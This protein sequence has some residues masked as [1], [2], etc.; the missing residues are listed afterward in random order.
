M[1][2]WYLDWYL[3]SWASPST[4]RLKIFSFFFW[5][6]EDF[7]SIFLFRSNK[8]LVIRS[9]FYRKVFSGD[10]LCFRTNVDG[11]NARTTIASFFMFT[12]R[13]SLLNFFQFYKKANTIL[14]KVSLKQIESIYPSAENLYPKIV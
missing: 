5:I 10:E 11:N 12:V 9:L 7:T 8:K 6:K 2:N 3:C 4:L 13:W 14:L 1:R